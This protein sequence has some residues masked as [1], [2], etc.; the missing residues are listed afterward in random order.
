MIFDDTLLLA[1]GRQ[2]MSQKFTL[3]VDSADPLD[4]ELHSIKSKYMVI[5]SNEHDPFQYKGIVVE[6][7]E[8]YTCIGTPVINASIS[9]Q[10]E[11]HI[12]DK[13]SHVRKFSSFLS[14]NGDAP[15]QVKEVTWS[16]TMTSSLM[17]SCES[18]LP[19]DLRGLSS[20]FSE[21][22]KNYLMLEARPA[23]I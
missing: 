6:R 5:N 20:R 18:W 4:M 21:L 14:K 1:T 8:K 16:A 17:Y 19:K 22:S 10:V 15:F 11:L 12:A 23:V 3:L 9:K 7:T 2:A 13:Q